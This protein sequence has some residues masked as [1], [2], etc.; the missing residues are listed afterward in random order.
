M[1]QKLDSINGATLHVYMLHVKTFQL[2]D[3]FTLMDS[4]HSMQTL[5]QRNVLS[6]VDL[7]V[8]SH[9]QM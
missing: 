5:V 1:Q 8:R 4:D 9:L 2:G 6:M 3:V 7:L